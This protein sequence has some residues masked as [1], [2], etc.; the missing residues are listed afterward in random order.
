MK[1]RNFENVL[2]IVD[3]ISRDLSFRE[4]YSVEILRFGDSP[5]IFF[6]FLTAIMPP[7]LE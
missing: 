4:I 3:F 1:R 5:L 2:L 6:F 7:P